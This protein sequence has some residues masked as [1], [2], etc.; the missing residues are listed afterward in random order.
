M[1]GAVLAETTHTFKWDSGA[2]E[3]SNQASLLTGHWETKINLFNS[4]MQL[5]SKKV[6]LNS[7]LKLQQCYLEHM[8]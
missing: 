2:Q 8:L 4:F 5:T 7:H 3:V 6:I 1:P